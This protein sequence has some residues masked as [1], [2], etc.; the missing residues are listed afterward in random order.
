MYLSGEFGTVKYAMVSALD[1]A[2]L[3]S[4]LKSFTVSIY[5]E[6][7]TMKKKTSALLAVTCF[8]VLINDNVI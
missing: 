1:Q 5:M 8:S 6:P 3:R 7:A 4:L 2:L